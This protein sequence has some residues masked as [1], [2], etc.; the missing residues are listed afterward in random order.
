MAA[1]V[2][3]HPGL[4][5]QRL[6]VLGTGHVAVV[7]GGQLSQTKAATERGSGLTGTWQVLAGSAVLVPFAAR[8]ARTRRCGKVNVMIRRKAGGEDFDGFVG[9]QGGIKL[10]LAEGLGPYVAKNFNERRDLEGQV[11]MQL[12]DTLKEVEAK[13]VSRTEDRVRINQHML[14]F[15]FL[16]RLD[17]LKD[18]QPDEEQEDLDDLNSVN[19]QLLQ[20]RGACLPPDLWNEL[21]TPD[22]SPFLEHSFLSGLEESGCVSLSRGWQPRFLLACRQGPRSGF[23]LVGAVPMYLKMHSEGEFCEE[24]EWI[25]ASRRHEIWHWPRLFVGVPFTPHRGRRLLTAAWLSQKDQSEVQEQLMRGLR[26][27]SVRAKC[28]MN[29]AFATEAENALLNDDGFILRTARQAWWTNRQPEPYKDFDDFLRMLR[30]K[31]AREIVKQRNALHRTEGVRID[32]ID[33]SMD[34][35]A[36]TPDL[37]SQVFRKCYLPTQLKHGNVDLCDDQYRCD[38]S[39]DFFRLLGEKLPHRLLLVLARDTTRG[40]KVMGGSMCLIKDGHIYGR[41]WGFRNT[42]EKAPFLHFECCYYA[43]IEHA[44]KQRYTRIE[45]GNGGG[46]IHKVQRRRGF[47]PVLTSSY[48]YVPHPELHEEVSQIAAEAADAAPSWVAQRNSAYTP[49]PREVSMAA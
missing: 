21:L 34:P 19:I 7:N 17:S 28:S 30:L 1:F 47:E 32:V 46:D 33:G 16:R 22:D 15:D 49:S 2:A 10:V 36:V 42:H 12:M 48:H 4:A 23:Q 31:N 3:P 6:S 35:S 38:L 11:E 13:G 18:W 24:V 37:M 29:I 25:E 26:A 43:V 39:E 8:R 41:Y 40:D 27:L 45:P 14:R 5:T 20:G 9:Q 44:I